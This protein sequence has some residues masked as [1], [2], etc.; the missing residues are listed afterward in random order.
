M[1]VRMLR[2]EVE[3]VVEELAALVDLPKAYGSL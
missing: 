3:V 2:V 1:G